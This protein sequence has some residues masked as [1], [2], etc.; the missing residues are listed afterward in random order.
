MIENFVEK[1]EE[2]PFIVLNK[3]KDINK[4]KVILAYLSNL[5]KQAL[6]SLNISKKN[7]NYVKGI[8]SALIRIQDRKEVFEREKVHDL[9]I[10][11]AFRL[12]QDYKNLK[13]AFVDFLF[14]LGEDLN[15]LLAKNNLSKLAELTEKL[16]IF[17]NSPLISKMIEFLGKEDIDARGLVRIYLRLTKNYVDYAPLKLERENLRK[18]SKK[19]SKFL[20]MSK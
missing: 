7:L 3:S 17:S 4:L 11:A 19:T 16:M 14:G 13:A 15:S 1:G 10:H 2:I 9:R 20:V 6:K 5:S 8:E 18:L 12:V